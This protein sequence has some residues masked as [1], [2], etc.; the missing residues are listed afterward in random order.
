MSIS[1]TIRAPLLNHRRTRTHRV[2]I[3]S[4]PIRTP[5]NSLCIR[6]SSSHTGYSLISKINLL[7]HNLCFGSVNLF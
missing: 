5:P 3:R 2:I 6:L 7:S 4:L 1:R